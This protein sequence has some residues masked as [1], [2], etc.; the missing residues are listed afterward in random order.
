[1]TT[2]S[3]RPVLVV[4][5][6]ATGSGKTDLSIRLAE[7]YS[8]PIIS[9]DSRQIYKGMPIGTAQPSAEQLSRIEHHFI[10]E[11]MPQQD[12][13][14]G[15]YETEALRRLEGLFA[16][17]PLVVAAGG[18]GLYIQA[19]CDGMDNLPTADKELRHTLK[20]RLATEGIEALA[21]ELYRL[22]PQC[23]AS[24]D[25]CNPARVMR[26]LEVCLLSGRPYSQQ[27]TGRRRERP[28][29]TIKIGTDVE[30]TELYRRI[31]LRVD[32]MVADGL[33]AEVRS[34][35]PL[36]TCNALQTVGYREIFDHIDGRTS[37]DEA[38]EAIKRNTR[39]YAKRQMTWFRR[40]PD[41]AWFAPDKVDDI[42]AYIDTKVLQN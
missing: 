28:F 14:C 39:R 18:S 36:R 29:R 6:G 10:A 20:Q 24:V 13:N 8:S 22:D 15:E 3:D 7:H 11:R 26:A 40:D 23:H 5:V 9:T 34:L 37:F 25:R 12:F 41:I 33:E 30:R 4:V 19:L 17:Y 16:R 38:V 31:D 21:D 27:C 2:I 1:M 42:I 35:L 32:R